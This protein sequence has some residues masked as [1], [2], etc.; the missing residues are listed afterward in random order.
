MKLAKTLY[1]DRTRWA[2][3]EGDAVCFLSGTPY[4]GIR[5]DGERA[6]LSACRLL[7]PC[8]ASK[9]VAIGKNYYDHAIEFPPIRPFLSSRTRRLSIRWTPLSIPLPPSVWTMNAS[10]RL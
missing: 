10:S 1:Q 8:D 7:A 5:L 3:L 2:V 6:P 4:D 9:V